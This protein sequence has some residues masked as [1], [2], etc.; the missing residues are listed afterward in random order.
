MK[1]EEKLSVVII[2]VVIQA[3]GIRVLR[4]RVTRVQDEK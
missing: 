2:K 1:E 4:G 3:K